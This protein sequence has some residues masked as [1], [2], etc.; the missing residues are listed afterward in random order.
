MRKLGCYKGSPC[1][2]M[3]QIHH[4]FAISTV[5]HNCSSTEGSQT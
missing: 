2:Y 3:P 5:G 1:R 4:R